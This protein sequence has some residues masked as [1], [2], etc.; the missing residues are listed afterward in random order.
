M[1]TKA[2]LEK[3]YLAYFG[4]PV[5]PTGL[6]DY[7]ASTDTQ[8]ADAFASSAES[9]SLYG[10][11]FNYAQINAIYLALFNREAEKA[12]LEYWYAKVADKTFTPAGAAIAIL[13][14]ALNADK[15]AIENKLA[16]SATFTA[17]LDTASEMIGYSGDAAAASARSFLSSVTTTAAT[18]AAVDAAVVAV[19]AAKTAVPAQTFTLTTGV[20][21]ITGTTGNDSI[22]TTILTGTAGS[23]FLNVT[24]VIDMKGGTDTIDV[25]YASSAATVSLA[26][27]PL[28][29]GVEV[30]N[31]RGIT[32]ASTMVGTVAPSLTSLG[33]ASNLGTGALAVT[34]APATLTTITLASNSQDD[35]DLSVTYA[36]GAFS[37]TADSLTLNVAAM[38]AATPATPAA[39][40]A[41]ALIGPSSG[42]G[43]E[44]INVVSSSTSR[45]DSLTSTDGTTQTMTTL[46]I[47]GAGSFRVNTALDFKST[48]GT[49]NASSNTG[50]VNLAV[51]T[52]NLTITTGSGADTITFGT[53]G[54][55]DANDTVILGEGTDTI[56]LADVAVSST[57]TALNA[58]INATAA[59]IIQFSAA[60]TGLDMSR[61]TASKVKTAADADMTITKLETTDTLIITGANVANR[62]LTLNASL[63][64]NTLNLE[65]VAASA[66]ASTTK[67]V[68][69]TSQANIN[70]VS[71]SDSAALTN[72]SGVLT[73]SANAIITI[74]GNGN[75]SLG[76]AAEG[77]ALGAAA[78]VNASALTGKLTVISAAGASSLTG[79]SAADTI[80]GGAGADTITGGAGADVLT[81]GANTTTVADTVT[82][83]LGADTLLINFAEDGGVGA[84]VLAYNATAAESFVSS[85]ATAVTSMDRITL[86]DATNDVD[87]ITFTTGVTTTQ[88]GAITVIATASA[89]V[90]GTTTTSVAFGFIVYNSIAEAADTIAP[91]YIAYQDT[92]G[93][94]IIEQGEFAVTIIGT[95]DA[96]DTEAFAV[97][98]GKLVLTFTGA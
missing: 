48:S 77:D 10:T 73:N 21:N 57:T 12:G 62:D 58:A 60:V 49:I 79:G 39:H 91:N 94:S 6:T 38:S 1:A 66:V 68:S 14:G 83:G 18:A 27:L 51:G 74:T 13:N 85:T 50:G 29:T 42:N 41:V 46:N 56:V 30:L 11:T 15:I 34:A 25:N 2:F 84:N 54:D 69:A 7:A 76:D 63:G 36:T 52:E 81:T 4:R 9:K 95:T 78:V 19:V 92:D 40:A 59:E 37:G 32:G 23:T 20:D 97:T 75:I 47:S 72:F 16:A 70:I 5:D 3:A 53:A 17:A 65:Y 44:T 80:T 31:L 98:G 61:I 90:I 26:A 82:P 71:T 45:L 28:L 67:T 93:D 64:F 35:T 86:R 89:P 43:L 88:S 22:S 87:T 55:L 8:V 96:S 33:V 24:D